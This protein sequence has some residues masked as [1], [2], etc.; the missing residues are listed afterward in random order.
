MGGYEPN[1]YY[2]SINVF[3]DKYLDRRKKILKSFLEKNLD[4][5]QTILSLASGR[6][7]NELKLIKEK[8][9]IT[10][11]DLKV[12]ECFKASKNISSIFAGFAHTFHRT[13]PGILPTLLT[14]LLH[15]C[16]DQAATV[17]M[18]R[19]NRDQF[20]NNQLFQCSPISF[21]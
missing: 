18:F 5:N 9:N 6:G 16:L 2:S 20:Y 1:E 21:L 13:N 10:C 17:S 12:P 19:E 7:I 3:F 11:S 4:K 15:Q 8:F 14:L